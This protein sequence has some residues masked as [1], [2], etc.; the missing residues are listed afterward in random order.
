MHGW[1]NHTH[2]ENVAA[3]LLCGDFNVK[4]G[5]EGYITVTQEYEDQFLKAT[6]R[7]IFDQV[8]HAQQRHLLNEDGRIDY[9]FMKKGGKLE[10]TSARMLFTEDN[11]GRVSDHFGYYV[12]FEPMW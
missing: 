11:Y 3:T 6:S 5:S 12:E 9:I 7:H 1:A 8:F 10:A 4:A 2:A